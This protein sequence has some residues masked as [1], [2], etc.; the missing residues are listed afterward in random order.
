MEIK[1]KESD[2]GNGGGYVKVSAVPINNLS[3]EYELTD[4][5]NMIFKT[6]DNRRGIN[7]LIC[8]EREN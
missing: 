8:L 7:H 3:S 1:Y 6:D 5:N 4:D 2:V